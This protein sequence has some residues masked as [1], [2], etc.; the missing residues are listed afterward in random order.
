MILYSRHGHNCKKLPALVWQAG[1]NTALLS[2][3]PHVSRYYR[4]NVLILYYRNVSL[5][6]IK[7]GIQNTLCVLNVV[8]HS[9]MPDSMRRM[10]RL[11]ASKFI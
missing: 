10:E 4:M 8:D 3:D 1:S 2:V 6:W 11:S 9:V 5:L 7:L